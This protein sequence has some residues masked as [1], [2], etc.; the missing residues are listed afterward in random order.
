MQNIS[1]S[2]LL[3]GICTS[4]YIVR[5][6]YLVERLLNQDHWEEL[7]Y[8]HNIFTSQINSFAIYYLTTDKKIMLCFKKLKQPAVI[9]IQQAYVD[10]QN[11]VAKSE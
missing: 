4:V 8:E 1:L 5:Q 2:L 9:D 7:S 3:R 6:L 11:C 10:H